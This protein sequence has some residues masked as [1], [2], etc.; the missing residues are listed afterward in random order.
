MTIFRNPVRTL[1]AFAIAFMVALPAYGEIS[2]SNIIV[3]FSDAKKRRDDIEISNVGKSVMYVAI[4]ATEII[5]PGLKGEERRTYQNPMEMGLLVAPRRMALEPGQT[6]T[7]RLSLLK[8]PVDKDRIYRIKIAPAVGRTIA[9]KSA[10]RILVGYE[11]LV[12]VRPDKAKPDI[13]GTR[14]GRKLTVRN[15]GNTNAKLIRGKQCGMDGKC[16]DLPPKRLYAGATWT[17]DLPLDAPA[18]YQI[19]VGENMHPRKF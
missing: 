18:E 8:R 14:T 9:T 4:E 5:R 6:K 15:T 10:I 16:V 3:D 2:V 13:S 11:A 7:V 17:V 19:K 12:I 1:S